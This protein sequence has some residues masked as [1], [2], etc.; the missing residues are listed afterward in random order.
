M[1]NKR[2]TLGDTELERRFVASA[3]EAGAVVHEVGSGADFASFIAGLGAGE[4]PVLSPTFVDFWPDLAAALGDDVAIA[5][6]DRWLH[7]DAPLGIVAGA[8]GISETGSVLV[9]ESLVA[10][11]VVS[12]LTKR[13]VALVPR[14]Q[15]L[16]DLDAAAS[17]I[18][19]AA[20]QGSFLSLITGPSRTADIERSMTIGVQGPGELHVVLA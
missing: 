15:L 17:L 10:D 14:R 6:N 2:S 8:C 19:D 9:D 13:T 12:M 7:A 3:T 20:R 4:T 11:R 5:T 1:I 18:A 16:A